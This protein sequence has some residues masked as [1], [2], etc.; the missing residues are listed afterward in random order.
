MLLRPLALVALLLPASASGQRETTR[1]ALERLEESLA[2][3]Q[4][5]GAFET[6]DLLPAIVVS[7]Q[8]AFEESKAWYPTAALATLVRVFGAPSLRSCEACRQ[9][10]LHVENARLE[11]NTADLSAEEI[12][13]LDQ[14]ARGS[15][16]PARTALW[17]DEN[18]GGVSLRIVDLANSRIVLA[19]NFD[20]RQVEPARTRHQVSLV[21]ELD[22]RARGDS[23]THA[24]LD[25]TVYPGQH[26][27]LDWVDQWGDTNANLSGVSISFLKPALGVGGAYYRIFPSL[28]DLSVGA[29]VLLS[30]PTAL[31]SSV[32]DIDSTFMEPLLTGVL[33]VRL[34][35]FRTNYGL[36]LSVS[37]NLDVG[38]G[39]SLLNISLLPF[40]P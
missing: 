15:A 7:A 36:T 13:R 16:A 24:I 39:L 20:P 12:A 9:P 32:S 38:I 28:W 6:K 31:V 29:K 4:T 23:L 21:T 35:L 30:L 19:E 11:Q 33:I 1:A 40:L 2:A 25:L 27:S 17:L 8:P 26:L 22:R 5:E 34:P 37:T 14:G 3:R 10:R 18:A